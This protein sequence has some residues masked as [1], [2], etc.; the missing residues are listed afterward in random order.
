MNG[1]TVVQIGA[2]RICITKPPFS[3]AMEI[4]AVR[5]LAKLSLDDYP[6]SDKLKKRFENEAEGV[7]VAGPPGSGKSTFVQAL[8]EFF[9]ENGNVVKTME[10]PR[11]LQVSEN[12]TQYAALEDNDEISSMEN[13]GDVLLLVRPDYTMYDEVR[14]TEDFEAFADLRLA[15]VGMVGVVH[16]A[17]AVDAIQRMMGRVE[18]GMIPQVVD[19][20]VFIDAGEISKVYS[21]ELTVKVPEG[22]VEQDLARPVVLE[23]DFEEDDPE[24]EIYTYGEETV[25]LPITGETGPGQEPAP[26]DRYAAA[27]IEHRVQEYVSNPDVEVTGANSIKLYVD[28]NDVP[29]IIG[30]GGERIDKIEDELGLSIQVESRAD[31]PHNT[32]SYT[33]EE[34]R[35][36]IS[37]DVGQKHAGSKVE[38]FAG[39]EFLMAATVGQ[40]GTLTLTKDADIA[41]RVLTAHAADTLT[42]RT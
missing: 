17:E 39:D 23:T 42:V 27:A 6:L 22:M 4:T 26:V 1:A 13:T 29:Q 34:H 14:K 5:P 33:L 28:D 20:V 7:F 36:K 41:D 16:A 2:L 21:L 12:I 31:A 37:L 9:D 35:D 40:D 32:A 11:D 10:Q 3:E 19:T 38:L 18:L 15:G 25:V 24:Y 8:A 30:K